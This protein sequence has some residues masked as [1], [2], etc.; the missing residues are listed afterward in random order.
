MF[1][2]V[3]NASKDTTRLTCCYFIPI[4]PF[5]CRLDP[6]STL[7]VFPWQNCNVLQSIVAALKTMEAIKAAFPGKQC[8]III[9]N[10]ETKIC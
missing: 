10:S 7:T 3:I 4:P 5:L 2:Y 8:V 1:T 9:I 6:K